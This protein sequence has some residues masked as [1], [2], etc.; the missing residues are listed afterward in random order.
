MLRKKSEIHNNIF[1]FRLNYSAHRECKRIV[2]RDFLA[3]DVESIEG[4]GSVGAVFEQV[5]FGLCEFFSGF[6]FAVIAFSAL[7]AKNPLRPWLT[8]A[9]WGRGLGR[10]CFGD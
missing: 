4:I 8:P 1:K 3:A 2:V 9:D 5:F 7:L 6:V 10:H